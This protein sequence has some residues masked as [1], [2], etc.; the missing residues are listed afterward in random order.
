MSDHTPRTIEIQLTQGY[1]AVID[2]CDVD[3][4]PLN[5]YA[6]VNVKQQWVGAIRNTRNAE[7]TRTQEWLHRVLLSR[8]LQRP[9]LQ[10]ELVDHVN[11]RSLDNRRENIRL[12]TKAGNGANSKRPANNT[13]GFKGATYNAFNKRWQS[14][15]TYDGRA[16]FLGY[17]DTAELAHEAYKQEAII[18]FGDFARYD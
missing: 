1:I 10:Q 5:W 17:F 7:G 14:Q 18:R 6:K 15:I 8:I 13:S 2:E 11:G 16:H 12:A 4:A 3:L 9:L